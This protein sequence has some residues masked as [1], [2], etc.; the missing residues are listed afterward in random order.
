LAD[1]KMFAA[2]AFEAR[3]LDHVKE[4]RDDAHLGPEL[5]VFVEVDAPGITA[6]LGENFEHVPLGMV[7]PAT[8]VHPLTL[9]I[10]RA[11]L[12]GMRRTE[13]AVA[14]VEPAIGSPRER[15]QR[16]VRVGLVIPTVQQNARIAR[17]FWI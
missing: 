9:A 16:F 12:A 5:A 15:V 1:R 8:G 11:R 14:T 7:A 6:A 10:R 4:V 3:A 17:G 2:L 13:N